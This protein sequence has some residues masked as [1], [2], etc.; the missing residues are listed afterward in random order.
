MLDSLI[1]I[2]ERGVDDLVLLADRKEARRESDAQFFRTID[3]KSRYRG[4]P[5]VLRQP[6]LITG[7]LLSMR[8]YAQAQDTEQRTA[9]YL[10]QSSQDW[11]LLTKPGVGHW[12]HID[13]C[14]ESG[15]VPEIEGQVPVMDIHSHPSGAREREALGAEFA[16]TIM[17][18]NLQSEHDVAGLLVGSKIYPYENS[19]QSAA[20]VGISFATLLCR[21]EDTSAKEELERTTSWSAF[22]DAANEIF[23]LTRA[24][25]EEHADKTKFMQRFLAYT[26]ACRKYKLG[27]YL[28]RLGDRA[29]TGDLWVRLHPK[30]RDV[31]EAVDMLFY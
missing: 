7:M 15:P 4:L 12:N 25:A 13:H 8:E 22:V 9:V 6:S 11:S 18:S 23:A 30:P 29:S 16:N 31:D 1:E 28:M 24:S 26:K 17:T 19:I 5:G 14:Y 21:T 10:D 2:T 3:G 27:L 20:V